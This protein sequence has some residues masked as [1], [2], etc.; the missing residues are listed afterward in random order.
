[1]QEQVREQRARQPSIEAEQ[2]AVVDD[3]KRPKNA[4]LRVTFVAPRADRVF[5]S[6]EAQFCV[7]PPRSGLSG[8]YRAS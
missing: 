4:K 1:M 6:A 2:S 5:S 3:L 8:D 7:L